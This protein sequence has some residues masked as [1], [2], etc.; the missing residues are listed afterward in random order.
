MSVRACCCG[1]LLLAVGV[2]TT[3]ADDRE[4]ARK[5][6]QQY[7]RALARVQAELLQAR[8]PLRDL[9]RRLKAKEHELYRRLQKHP[10]ITA[11]AR[12]RAADPVA[13]R[14]R[15]THVRLELLRGDQGLRALDE[16]VTRLTERLSRALAREPQVVV[17]RRRLAAAEA[18]LGAE[19]E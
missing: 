18:R 1:L 15:Y 3:A 11:I 19:V 8:P 6:V 9:H 13:Y 12:E 2:A 10:R 7:R 14:R 4:L 16:E 5:R 17:L